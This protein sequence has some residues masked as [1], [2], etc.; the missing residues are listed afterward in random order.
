MWS[1]VDKTFVHK[2]HGVTYKILDVCWSPDNIDITYYY[3]FQ[4]EGC[5]DIHYIL[6]SKISGAKWIQWKS[7]KNTAAC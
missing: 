2:E 1:R 3:K 4:A 7:D 6:C 5:T